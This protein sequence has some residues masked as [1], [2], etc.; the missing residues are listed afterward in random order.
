MEDA[1]IKLADDIIEQLQD[2]KSELLK[3]RCPDMIEISVQSVRGSYSNKDHLR[4]I[5]VS[6]ER[7]VLFSKK[8][9][10]NEFIELT[11]DEINQIS[12]LLGEKVVL[13]EDI[14]EYDGPE[15]HEMHIVGRDNWM[16]T[17]YNFESSEHHHVSS[18]FSLKD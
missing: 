4:S 7:Q 16:S 17:L 14:D 3:R 2:M 13:A 9:P 5:T 10:D 1:G 11:I 15:Y 12:G 6:R 18:G 8:A